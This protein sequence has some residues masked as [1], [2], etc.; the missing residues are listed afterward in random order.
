MVKVRVRL[1]GKLNLNM[2]K[3][4]VKSLTIDN[5]EEFFSCLTARTEELI[6]NTNKFTLNPIITTFDAPEEKTF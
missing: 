6:Y 4:E 2:D 3:G 5:H 1:S